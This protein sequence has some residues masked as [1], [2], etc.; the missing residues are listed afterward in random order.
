[1]EDE[2]KLETRRDELL[3]VLAKLKAERQQFGLHSATDPGEV[4]HATIATLTKSFPNQLKEQQA[5]VLQQI[6]GLLAQVIADAKEY[7]TAHSPA[8]DVS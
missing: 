1:M 7:T 2:T 4:V 8:G 6:T 3:Q 5:G